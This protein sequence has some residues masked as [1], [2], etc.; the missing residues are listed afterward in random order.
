MARVGFPNPFGL[1]VEVL[2]GKTLS[3]VFSGCT[4]DRFLNGCEFLIFSSK[5]Q[6]RYDWVNV[7][8]KDYQKLE[9]D[10]LN[11]YVFSYALSV[12]NLPDGLCF[13]LVHVSAVD[14]LESI[15]FI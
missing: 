5:L 15:Y 14:K 11:C 9:R 3:S 10:H 2:F 6:T 1:T 4:A 7:T 12:F 8:L 13:S